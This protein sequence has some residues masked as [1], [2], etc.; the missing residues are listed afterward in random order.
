MDAGQRPIVPDARALVFCFTLGVLAVHALREL[1]PLSALAAASLLLLIRFRFRAHCAMVLLG[2]VLTTWMAREQLERRWPEAR[3]NEELGVRGHIVSLPEINV[4]TDRKGEPARTWRFQFQ[5]LDESMPLTRVSWYR[6]EADLRGGECWQ[7]SLRM[8]TPH[9]SFNPGGFDYEAWL[10]RLGIGATATVKSGERCADNNG[11][12]VLKL[13]QRIVEKI[14][15]WLPKHPATALVTALVVGDDSGLSDADWDVFRLT[16]TSHLVVISGFN[17]GIVAG[18][19]FFLCRWLWCLWPSLCLRLPAQK[20]GMLGSALAA[21]FYSLLAGFEPPVLRALLMLLFMLAALWM[22]RLSQV[23]RVLALAWLAILLFDPFAVMSPGLWLS[24]GA[25]AAIFYLAT[26]RLRAVG[27][28]RSFILIQLMLSLALAP[29]TLYFFH[30]ASVAGPLVNLLAVPLFALLTPLLLLAVLLAWLWP[31]AGLP[32]LHMAAEALWQ[33]RLALEAMASQP[34]LWQSASPAPAALLLSALGVLL[35]FAP[36]RLPLWPLALLCFVPLLFPPSQSPREGLEMTALDVG[37]GLAV[38]LRTQNHALLFDAGPA[39]EDGFD[40]GESVVAP[41]L[42]SRGVSELDLML[43]SHDHNDHTGGAPS[44][45]RLLHV[46]DERGA[47]TERA[48]RDGERWD[49]DGVRFELLHPEAAGWGENNVSCVLRVEVGD[50]ALLLT[51]DIE[52]AAEAR[53]LRD[54]PELLYA[55]VLLAPHHGSKTSSTE[56]FVEAVQP[57]TVIHSAG[58]RHHFHHPHPSV[59]RRYATVGARQFVTGQQG[60][61]SLSMTAAGISPISSHR[62]EAAHWWNAAAESLDTQ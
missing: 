8:K 57:K 20:A 26:G 1:P 41:F 4:T 25:V 48:C 37:Q 22:N 36:R 50:Y 9:G 18:V 40:A 33:F 55:D 31:W 32:L 43:L 49:W 24:F 30:G 46:R 47:A 58:W 10:F 28:L 21:G 42:L 12:A 54:H 34:G 15:V 16:G 61:L 39:F 53:L 23:S 14:Q 60:A 62:S 44:L 56:T 13:R 29:L 17:I 5:P 52:K 11:S 27:W 2:V 3:H 45:R 35:L 59:V 7:L 38:V 19:A 6:S 51:G